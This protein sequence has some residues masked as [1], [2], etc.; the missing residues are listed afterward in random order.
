MPTLNTTGLPDVP[1]PEQNV[2]EV[3]LTALLAESAQSV[4]AAPA[5]HIETT[6]EMV[7]LEQFNAVV[8][9]FN[10]TIE[11]M[12]E[13]EAQLTQIVR[14]Q[15]DTINSLVQREAKVSNEPIVAQ[16]VGKPAQASQFAQVNPIS[17]LQSG[18]V[19]MPPQHRNVQPNQL[20]TSKK[21]SPLDSQV[22]FPSHDP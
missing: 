14:N 16:T 9:Q 3:D 22:G 21:Q 1:E 20:S 7:T 5:P 11:A 2:P 19:G 18:S 6:P 10:Q 4:E 15:Q 17:T 8:E 13:R 12:R